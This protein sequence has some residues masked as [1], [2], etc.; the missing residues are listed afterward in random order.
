MYRA[1]LAGSWPVFNEVESFRGG[2]YGATETLSLRRFVRDG[3][4]GLVDIKE[5]EDSVVEVESERDDGRRPCLVCFS[6]SW[7]FCLCRRSKS[8]K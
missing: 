2:G 5:V 1:V 6:L 4:S 3:E 8:L 7:I